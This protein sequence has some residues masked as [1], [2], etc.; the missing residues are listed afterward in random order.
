M[1]SGHMVIRGGKITIKPLL[2]RQRAVAPDI[3]IHEMVGDKDT[4]AAEF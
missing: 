1:R 4:R 3:T 2:I